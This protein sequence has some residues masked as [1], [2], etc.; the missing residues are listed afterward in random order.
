MGWLSI[1]FGTLIMIGGFIFIWRAAI[2]EQWLGEA[3]DLMGFYQSD[4]LTWKTVGL[5]FLIFG[6]LL[7]TGLLYDLFNLF[8][9]NLFFLRPVS[10]G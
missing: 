4:W 8:F 2:L 5:F 9:G 7:A 3:G 1:I 10:R 6:F